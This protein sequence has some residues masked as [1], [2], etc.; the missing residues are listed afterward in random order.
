MPL[1]RLE[2]FLKNA[3][4]NI[5]YVN[6]SDFDSTDSFENQG[7]SLARPFKTIQ[8]ALIEA[9]RFSYQAGANN[10]RID[11]TSILVYPGTHYIDNRPGFS[12]EEINGAAVYKRRTGPETWEET[13]ISEF[14]IGTN[15]DILDS[16]ND[17]YKYNSTSGGV[18]LPRGTSI[19]GLDLRKTKVRPLFV[20]DPEDA[21]ID[22]SSIFNVTGTCY[23]T[24]FTIFD[25]DPTKTVYKDYSTA[26]AVPNFSH[27]KL[28]S[29]TFADGVSKVKLGNYQTYLTDLDMY[30]YKVARAYGDITGR[31]LTDFPVATDF[32]PNV[33]EFRIVGSLDPNP[34][35]ISSIRAGN[36]DGTGDLNTITVTT[37]NKQ[38]GNITP[39][40]LFI[41]SPFLI[42][43]V[44]VDGD[45]YNGSFTVDSVVGIN[46]FTFVT[47][48]APGE[49][50]PDATEFDTAA[51][52][53]GSDTVSSASP[54]I[55]NCS[56]RSVWGMSGMWA[57]GSKSRGFKSMVTAQFTG[58]SLQKDDNAFMIYDEGV[59]YDNSTLPENS[60]LRPLHN[61]S[62]A[63]YKPEYENYHIRASDNGFIQAVSVFAIGYSRH[64]LTESGGDM[65]ITN[66]NSNFG[67]TSLESEGFKPESFDR[68]DT[69]YI[70]HIIPPKEVVA[71]ENEVTWLSLDTIKT[72]NA[73]D[74]SRL[75][76]A[77]ASNR[78]IVPAFQVD[79]YR[80][81]AK[82]NDELFL[83]VTIGTAQTSYSSPIM[84]PV[85][86][87]ID[88]SARKEYKVARANGENNI[89][90][91][92]LTLTENHQF[93]NGEK[94][95]ILS[96]TGETPTGLSNEGL[97]FVITTGLGNNQIRLAQSQ[98]DA[99][100]NIPILGITN[101]GGVLSVVSRVSDKLPGEL[102]HP[103]QFD[104]TES[105]WYVT[106]EANNT[107]YNTIVGIGTVQLGTETSS[108]FIK[109]KLD[110]RS[111]DDK[112]F[113]L[114]YVIPKEFTN[115][116]PPEAGYVIQESKTVGVSSISYTTDP[117]Q[118]TIELR[119]ER[120]ITSAVAGPI[121]NNAQE[122]TVK[123]ELP[124]NLIAGDKVNVQ[125]ITSNN[126][127]FATGITSTYNGQHIVEAV[128]N[129]KEFKYTITGVT[130][131][132]GNFTNDIDQ[133]VT[134]QQREALPVFSRSAYND[135]YFIY[136]VSQVKKHIPGADGQDGIYHLICLT[137]NVTPEANVGFGLDEK[138]FNLD[139]KNLYPQLDRDNI[140]TNP[141]ASTSYASLDVIGK[142][143]TSDKRHSITREGL[144]YFTKNTGVGIALTGV[145]ISGAGN[146]TLTINTQIEHNLNEIKSISFT[147]GAGYPASQTLYS[148]ELSNTVSGGEGATARVTTN[149]SGEV[150]AVEII[151]SGSG[152]AV[153][154][155]LAIPGTSGTLA[156]VT[157]TAVND[158]VGSAIELNG[159][160]AE[161]LNNVF[162]VTS[163][164][165]PNEIVLEAP[166]GIS[167]YEPNTNGEL[168]YALEA[169]RV[170]GITSG[171][172]TD[173]TTGIAT[174]TTNVAHGLNAGN[175][176][177][178]VNAD[179]SLF[180]DEFV[181][182]EVVG[183][184]T[185]S[186]VT[187]GAADY[188]ET[189]AGDVLKRAFA[190]QGKNI[191]R[192]E[193]GLAARASYLY[194]GL[195][196]YLSAELTTDSGTI[197]F[198]DP[199]GINRGDYFIIN[200]EILRIA[201]TTNPF[202][203]L[204]GQLGTFKSSAPVDS[205]IQRIRVLP[206]EVRRPSFMRASGHTFEYLGF[207][208]GNYSTGM[209]QKQDRIL[210]EDEVLTSQA[211][212]QRGGSV[213]YTGMNDLGEFYSGSKKLSS[214]TGEETV[215]EAPILT[216]TGDD[217]QG[218]STS[219][220]SGIFD[221]LLV[222]QRLT[223]EGGENNNQSSQFYGPVNFTQKVTNLSEAGTE[224][225]NLFLKGT[226]AQ[227]KLVT[228][229]ISTP[230]T[231]TIPSPRSGDIALLANPSENYLGHV[232]VGNEW[233]QF[234]LISRQPDT[235]DV[236]VDKLHVNTVGDSNFQF[237]A[238][239]NAKVNNLL[240]DGQVTFS[241]PQSL[242]SVTFENAVVNRTAVFNGTGLDP[243]T[244]VQTNYT[245][246][247]LRGISQL[248]DLEVS[249]ISTFTGRADFE[250]NIFGVGAKFGNIRIGIADDNTIDTVLGDLTINTDSGRVIVQDNV[251][252]VGDTFE[253]SS[254]NALVAPGIITAKLANGNV[255]SLGI[256]NT[257][258]ITGS[259]ITP[260]TLT[261]TTG[262]ET[263]NY[264]VTG[265]GRVNTYTG[266]QDPT[267]VMYVGDTITFD[268]SATSANHPMYIRETDGGSSVS[269]PAATG[270][271]TSTVS[272][273]PTTVGTYYYQ[274]SVHAAMLGTIE[275][276][277]VPPNTGVITADAAIEMHSDD[278]VYPDGSLILK[279]EGN[280]TATL[281]HRG[282]APLILNGQDA[283]SEISLRTNN[284][285]RVNVGTSGTVT[286]FQD[287]SETE[288]KGAHI[289]LTQA[290][291]GDAVFSWDITNNNANKRWYAGIDASDAHAWKLAHPEASLQYGQESFDNSGETKLRVAVTGDTTVGGNLTVG[292]N[293]LDSTSGSFNL[294]TTP[295]I[296][297]AFNATTTLTIGA[298]TNVSGV[299]LRGTKGST[300]TTT[301]ALTVAGG[302]G[303]A[304]N[305]HV[306][307][308]HG[309]TDIVGFLKASG[310]TDLGGN[311]TVTGNGD[312][313]GTLDVGSVTNIGGNLNV[314]GNGDF[315]GTLDADSDIFGAR[316]IKKQPG[317]AKNFLRADGS[318]SGLTEKDL[319]DLLGFVPG[320][321]VAS[322]DFPIGNSIILDD[323]SA[324]F[325]G[326]NRV[327]NLTRDG[328]TAFVPIGPANLIVSLGGV[329]QKAGVDYII[330]TISG[331]FDSKI[332]FSNT[333]DAPTSGMGCFILA[334][335]GQGSLVANQDWGNKGEILIGTGDN[336]AIAQSKGN[337]GQVLT[338]AAANANT[339]IQWKDLP[340]G[341]PVGSIVMWPGSSAPTGWHLCNG[342]TISQSSNPTLYSLLGTTFGGAG[343][344]P[345]FTNKFPTMR[346]STGTSGGV[347]QRRIT[348]QYLPGHNHS[349]TNQANHGHTGGPHVHSISG[350]GKHG[351]TGGNTNATGV[352]DHTL[353]GA[354]TS[355]QNAHDHNGTTTSEGKHNHG[356][357]DPGHD[358]RTESTRGGD[359][360]SGGGDEGGGFESARSGSDGTG[361]TLDQQP[362]HRHNFTTGPGGGHS[363]NL[364]GETGDGGGH[365]HNVAVAQGGDHNH[366]GNTGQSSP[367]MQ[368]G[369]GGA[370]NHGGSV[371]EA[372][373]GSHNDFPFLNPYLSINFI[374][375][376]G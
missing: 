289:K 70:S 158:G 175:K 210:D 183:I 244:G 164:A 240:I 286:V 54:Y 189:S 116:K 180:V 187:F 144:D 93:L 311:L 259:A 69:G 237:E 279:K 271:G 71:D 48:N 78:E 359:T 60:T 49:V 166:V 290:G 340:E 113:K 75:Y 23:F 123:T 337:E 136:R 249:G 300:S 200:G 149:S 363:H 156:E 315:T 132:P 213:V 281:T 65:S 256:G 274:C 197:S 57:D 241:Q 111:I 307:G 314:T 109:R 51:L 62:R 284:T 126:N 254:G 112:L 2:N 8:R 37:A 245:Q 18:V 333:S 280:H 105:N 80:I 98:N 151:D 83:T 178:I 321:P 50:L 316:I 319:E 25:G 122:V 360:K 194:E 141:K 252:Q 129:S 90:N 1:S 121:I 139:V 77:G 67:N 82:D 145:T 199:T 5:L 79:G 217:S 371:S 133:R 188:T 10:D 179:S 13:T 44:S 303:I 357:R 173:I 345:N 296:V 127:P 22:T 86:S 349:I 366:G 220:S 19:I 231:L 265:S 118:N 146:T 235:L 102:G 106:S 263:G 55:F 238:G 196:G 282:G 288:L 223:V 172:L 209:P 250:T 305:L 306:G 374:I 257:G 169:G 255:L 260:T 270:E 350:S 299:V 84:M 224:T 212:E 272:W 74:T 119:N 4:G 107:I 222:R 20:P 258:G 195:T 292:G 184:T 369:A 327:F 56:L 294:I 291:T 27:H 285:E 167:T 201:N 242:G 120:V 229:G 33:D 353:T 332:Q 140:D 324:S 31:G 68:D 330:P 234:G 312:I 117:L 142:V 6:P 176:V 39:H 170:V 356:V 162:K 248:N 16:N 191:G 233:R 347:D 338:V 26:Q 11:R 85:P 367:T 97:Y 17:L 318:D 328:G 66:S 14:G 53:I 128:T 150:T 232:R 298:N 206:V 115:A 143:I 181:V 247:H 230:T 32:E 355:A 89:A 155:T 214:A 29:F 208:P 313:G 131:N 227:S 160:S 76:L 177:R 358:H 7:N 42:N 110:N 21:S 239:G 103:M 336:T 370:H 87:G 320:A 101:N 38:T 351:H 94:I 125:K 262:A 236:R 334:L 309:N 63:I 339:G 283:G 342:A 308:K 24:A 293:T 148:K 268:N 372:Y 174:F 96:D 30:Y 368:I 81:G 154:D 341:V 192:G 322:S 267:I 228:V 335:G 344:L 135:T 28:V 59:F 269:N 46:T 43:G 41:N 211:K 264:L 216:Y 3:E 190:P 362:A 373:G 147:A 171:V 326:S 204:R 40:N 108:T 104:E 304:E 159:F 193:E 88:V 310:D 36:G 361:I 165:S 207:G 219:V 9:A 203:V 185:F 124:H 58:I 64:F 375:K 72:I 346:G 301:G 163:V 47:N 161:D 205:A 153:N 253:Q 297:N 331:N 221:E 276:Q 138:S 114:R 225:K 100:S 273:T 186:V 243:I 365:E 364:K 226:A 287:N 278:R 354:M 34:L 352:H 157:V 317:A 348:S 15:Y 202:T 323:I 246:I 215:I 295:T 92:I 137:S 73:T 329:V 134:R 99:L 182:R 325:D 35:G 251:S 12:I 376:A 152:Y 218:E 261:F 277:A 266:Q 52:T 198:A 168:G 343:K 130:T 95:R 91:N 302:V 61:N 275:V 45:S